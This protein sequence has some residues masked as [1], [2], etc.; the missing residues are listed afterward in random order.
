MATNTAS[1]AGSPESTWNRIMQLRPAVW[2]LYLFWV[3]PLSI[4]PPLMLYYAGTHHGGKLMPAV[5]T[6][7]LKAMAIL[8]FVVEV[9][10]VPVMALV[11]QK[12]GQVV[13]MTPEYRDTFRLA[14]VAPTPLWIAPLFLFVPSMLLNIAISALAMMLAAL[15]IFVGVDPVFRLKDAGQSLLMAG[16]ILAAGLVGWVIMVILALVSW[17]YVVG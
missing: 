14:S 16:A 8:F 15:L 3:I 17:G 12:L 7:E 11:V 2:Q 4:I 5:N 6:G 13:E 9:V 1:G 10:A